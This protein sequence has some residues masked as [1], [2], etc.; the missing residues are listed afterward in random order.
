[1]K[2]SLSA[3]LLCCHLTIG[4]ALSQTIIYPLNPAA[5]Y[6][7]TNDDI[8]SLDAIPLALSNFGIQ[9]GQII[10][11]ERLGFFDPGGT[12]GETSASLSAVFSASNTLLSASLLNRVQDAIDA[13][14]DYTS[15]RTFRGNLLTDIPEDFTLG[16]NG[17]GSIDIVVPTGA[18][19][20]FF[21][22]RDP[23][24]GDNTDPNGDYGVAVTVVPEPAS[25]ALTAI[26]VGL[27]LAARRRTWKPKNGLPSN[28]SSC[29]FTISPRNPH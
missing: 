26:G 8:G 4:A 23:Y 13:G 3:A 15:F 11:I 5:T 27:F 20:L 14:T 24:F 12:F 25:T 22:P 17:S 18:T 7:L 28:P 2:I 10:R 29:P 21:S 16:S 19:H 6:L 9:P 1:M